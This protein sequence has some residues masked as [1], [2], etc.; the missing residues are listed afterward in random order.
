MPTV[1]IPRGLGVSPFTS[2][3]ATTAPEGTFGGLASTLGE[4]GKVGGQVSELFV[5]HAEKMAAI[6][7]RVAAD[8]AVLSAA[9]RADKFM[10]D[11]KSANQGLAASEKLG[12]AYKELE[13][14]RSE[15]GATLKAPAAR[16]LYN[17]QS[18]ISS[19]QARQN[20]ASF[21]ASERLTHLNNEADAGIKL[22]SRG[23]TAENFEQGVEALK[24]RVALKGDINGWEIGRAHV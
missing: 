22:T 20:L 9:E 6:D 5:Q 1:P 7:N 23:L 10:L 14:I 2:P 15:A 13:T 4:V 19:L 3:Q 11:F 24:A 21:A 17:S 12:E 16:D 8:G 18:R